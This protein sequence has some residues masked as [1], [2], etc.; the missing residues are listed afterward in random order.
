[1]TDEKYMELALRLAKKGRGFANPN[2]MVGAVVVKKGRII[3]RG[4]HHSYGEAHAERDALRRCTESPEGATLYV[5]LEPCCHYGKTPPCTEAIIE[6]GI[7]R[8][9]IGTG[10]PNPKVSGGGV[11]ALRESGIEVQ[12][13]VW[14]EECEKLNEVFFH[15]VRTGTPFVTMKYAM[16]MDGKIA[17]GAGISKWITSER[18][19]ARV[20]YDRHV[21][22][23]VMTG[24]GTVLADDPALTCHAEGLRDPVRVICDTNP[25]TPLESQIVRTAKLFPVILATGVDDEARIAPYRE[26]GCR[27]MS[28]PSANGKIC[29]KAL[30]AALGEEKI[31]SVLLEGGSALNWEALEAGVVD[32]IQAYIAPKLLGGAA[33]PGPIGGEGFVSPQ[34]ACRLERV[35]V[36]SI[37]TDFLLEGDVVHVHGD[38]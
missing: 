16:T 36:T 21:N 34:T 3:G 4:Y 23:A 27:V 28:L 12:E 32:R 20:H 26:R 17:S 5:T 38:H 6:S 33:A 2:P 18:A 7:S 24:I 13:G 22:M 11:R 35:S 30:L 8:V 31:D 1:M 14:E 15:F 25:R 19:R 10:D 29:L 37:G 9:V